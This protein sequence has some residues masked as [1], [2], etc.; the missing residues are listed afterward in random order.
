MFSSGRRLRHSGRFP[1][2]TESKRE[3]PGSFGRPRILSV[4]LANPPNKCFLGVSAFR[5]PS[6]I[7][8]FK[9]LPCPAAYL[10]LCT[11]VVLRLKPAPCRSGYC[12]RVYFAALTSVVI[13]IPHEFPYIAGFAKVSSVPPGADGDS[14]DRSSIHAILSPSLLPHIKVQDVETFL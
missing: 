7:S 13:P 5:S 1:I 6:I 9:S 3:I 12:P 11:P 2:L 14:F 4:P 10:R 8:Q